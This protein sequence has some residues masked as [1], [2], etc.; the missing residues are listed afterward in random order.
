[1]DLSSIIR[2]LM[3]SVTTANPVIQILSENMGLIADLLMILGVGYGIYRWLKRE[4]K[5]YI[6]KQIESELSKIKNK[7]TYINAVTEA[8]MNTA[9]EETQDSKAKELL[10]N[11]F[12]TLKKTR[13]KEDKHG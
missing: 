5:K 13:D 7:I 1:M 12:E 6:K 3:A 10:K 4:S 11:L 8:L 9:I 2:I